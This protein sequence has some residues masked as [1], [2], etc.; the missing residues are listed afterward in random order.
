MRGRH[1]EVWER[2]LAGNDRF[3][4][5]NPAPRDFVREREAVVAGQRPMAAVLACSDSRVDIGVIFDVPLGTVFAV[6]TAGGV[7]D[8]A[9][10]GSLEYAVG[11]LKVPL[12]VVM[13]HD[14]CGA[15]RAASGS[16]LPEGALGAVVTTVRKNISGAAS[17]EDAIVQHTRQVAT[18]LIT[19]SPVLRQACAAGALSVVAAHYTLGDGRV[20]KLA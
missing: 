12:L 10:L 11:H 7:A 3:V 16:A 6:K 18:D 9:A 19:R 2:L 5:G 14:D 20:V 1:G 17:F 15:L 4:Q 13:G 8:V